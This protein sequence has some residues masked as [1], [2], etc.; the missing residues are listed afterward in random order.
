MKFSEQTINELTELFYEASPSEHYVVNHKFDEKQPISE[1]LI[2]AFF[3]F[4]TPLVKKRVE[5]EVYG[6]IAKNI[7]NLMLK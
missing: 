3:E 5:D 6:K 2:M 4:M 7:T 1:E